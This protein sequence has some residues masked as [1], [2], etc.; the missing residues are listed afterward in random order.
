[1]HTLLFFRLRAVE[2]LFSSVRG[3]LRRGL[4]SG[5]V[6]DDAV[7]N[8]LLALST[9]YCNGPVPGGRWKAVVV[10]LLSRFRFWSTFWTGTVWS[11]LLV[12]RRRG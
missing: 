6:N 11:R 9:T 2:A 10:I 3:P 8:A 5:N 1:M 7:T 12:E 4:P